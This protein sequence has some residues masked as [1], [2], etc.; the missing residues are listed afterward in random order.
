[1]HIHFPYLR[2]V[3]SHFLIIWVSHGYPYLGPAKKKQ[4][5]KVMI[6]F[7][8]IYGQ[9]NQSFEH[10]NFY[11][12]AKSESRLK[13]TNVRCGCTTSLHSASY[14]ATSPATW[15]MTDFQGG[16]GRIKTCTKYGG[17]M[18]FHRDFIRISNGFH[19]DMYLYIY[20]IYTC[21]TQYFGCRYRYIHRRVYC[22][23]LG[24]ALFLW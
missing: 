17:F 16:A 23:K 3:Q 6:W 13:K 4:N 5:V 11:F 10:F 2:L 1:M 20:G 9:E 12:S 14:S 21:T 8:Y 22:Q 18:G 19:R 15:T 24:I 7:I